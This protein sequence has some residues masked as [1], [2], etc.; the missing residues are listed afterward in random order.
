[1]WIHLFAPF[2]CKVLSILAC[3]DVELVPTNG[4]QEVLLLHLKQ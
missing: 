3:F 4:F 2:V 1:M